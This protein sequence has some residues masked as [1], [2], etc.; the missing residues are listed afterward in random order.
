[1]KP[2]NYSPQELKTIVAAKDLLMFD[3]CYIDINFGKDLRCSYER[4][5]FRN[6][7]STGYDV[8]HSGLWTFTLKPSWYSQVYLKGLAKT[9][10]TGYPTL[11]M[12]AKPMSS[13]RFSD[14][15]SGLGFNLYKVQVPSR[16]EVRQLMESSFYH[17]I[18]NHSSKDLIGP[19]DP[20]HRHTM[21]RV[22]TRYAVNVKLADGSYSTTYTAKSA[23]RA[24]A[25]LFKDMLTQMQQNM[26]VKSNG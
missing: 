19:S 26:G 11:I 24:A 1:M 9:K 25:S 2:L 18:D 16:V 7:V 3:N 5:R 14:K 23:N 6:Y 17:M 10:S 21:W 20:F 13:D 4:L 15:Y 22:T 8:N 12:D